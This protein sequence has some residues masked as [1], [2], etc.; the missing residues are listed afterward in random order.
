MSRP[1]VVQ[2][3]PDMAAADAAT[4]AVE[5][6]PRPIRLTLSARFW[7]PGWTIS[8]LLAAYTGFRVPNPFSPT[9]DTVSLPDGFH[10]RFLVGTLLRPLSQATNYDYW[11]YTTVA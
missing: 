3:R 6:I 7:A 8:L 5:P 4:V 11:L 10:R 2:E 1:L 9:L